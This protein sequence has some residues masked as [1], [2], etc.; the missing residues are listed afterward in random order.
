MELEVEIRE[1]KK[2]DLEQVLELVRELEI[3]LAEKFKSVEIKSGV[4]D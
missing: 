1:Y 2:E 3:E 4:E